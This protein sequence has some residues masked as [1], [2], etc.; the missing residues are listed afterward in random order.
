MRN[1]SIL[2]T[3][4]T[5]LLFSDA[6]SSQVEWSTLIQGGALNEA[7]IASGFGNS[8]IVSGN[9]R[10]DPFDEDGFI[11]LIQ[12]TSGELALNTPGLKPG[13]WWSDIYWDVSATQ[14]SQGR[15]K[16]VV[17]VGSGHRTR[18]DFASNRQGIVDIFEL[19]GD[20]YRLKSRVQELNL[21]QVLATTGLNTSNGH[22]YIGGG[23]FNRRD[24]ST[25]DNSG[26]Y[27]I[28]AKFDLSGRELWR[29]RISNGSGT[30]NIH[31]MTLRGTRLFVA[32]AV[33]GYLE[34]TRDPIGKLDGFIRVYELNSGYP[35]LLWTKRFKTGWVYTTPNEYNDGL[36]SI[37][38][39]NSYNIYIAGWTK[40]QLENSIP[41]EQKIRIRGGQTSSFVR[42]FNANGEHEWLKQFGTDSDTAA[43]SIVVNCGSAIYVG[44]ATKGFFQ[45]ETRTET[46]AHGGFVIRL[47]PDG[48]LAWADSDIL[49]SHHKETE[50]NFFYISDMAVS[51]NS[52]EL[53]VGGSYIDQWG[54]QGM[55]GKDLRFAKI[56]DT[57]PVFAESGGQFRCPTTPINTFSNGCLDVP[58]RRVIIRRDLTS[59]PHE[60]FR[61]D[62][63]C[64]NGVDDDSDG[65]CDEVDP[66]CAKTREQ[67]DGTDNCLPLGPDMHRQ[68]EAPSTSPLCSDGIDNDEDGKCDH[69]EASCG[70]I[71]R[72]WE[73]EQN[74]ITPPS[75][76]LPKTPERRF[77]ESAPIQLPPTSTRQLKLDTNTCKKA[78]QGKIAWDYKGS[79]RW[80][81]GN[82]TNLCA[83]AESSTEPAK[84]F[85]KVMHGNIS[86][87]SGNKW[88]WK[89]AINLC[90]GTVSANSTIGCFQKA[91]KTG[92]S[93]QTAINRCSSQ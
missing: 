48:T 63:T 26:Y 65:L 10:Q 2:L 50:N 61:G 38:V 85:N 82:I 45:G 66:D 5:S 17:A 23:Q 93:W 84:C 77:P 3:L 1:P 69:M 39:D 62:P 16:Y 29:E 92:E 51:V 8:L 90:K 20:S 87:G 86:W 44:G 19:K 89:N 78:V 64:S 79:K 27:S 46:G 68:N 30:I 22:F 32:G 57:L 36:I 28:I 75:S 40:T 15:P 35:S 49:K 7:H 56:T 59:V 4:F 13:Q 60:G 53:Y 80:A 47:N 43:R 18:D 31:S 12:K 76:T 14:E 34:G 21:F 73:N 11:N 33:D 54:A 72:N 25:R 70:A 41:S 6:Y 55:A 67:W 81:S 83:G 74:R 58:D 52:N 88:Q 91:I 42:K 71:A 24:D 9:L 37:A